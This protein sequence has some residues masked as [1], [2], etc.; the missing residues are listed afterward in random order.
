MMFSQKYFKY[1][2]ESQTSIL[3]YVVKTGIAKT[4]NKTFNGWK[5]SVVSG[6]LTLT[7]IVKKY[8]YEHYLPSGLFVCVSWVR[9]KL[10]C[11]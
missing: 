1:D 10:L 2:K 4:Y 3:E 6:D 11:S 8:I 5:Y 9:Q 7:R